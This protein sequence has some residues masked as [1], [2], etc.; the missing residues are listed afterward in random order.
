[1]SSVGERFVGDT[2]GKIYENNKMQ[3]AYDVSNI[4][5]ISDKLFV[6]NDNYNKLLSDYSD[7][8]SSGK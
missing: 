2:L 4:K 5:I 3:N 7:Y 8:L 1:L 6:V